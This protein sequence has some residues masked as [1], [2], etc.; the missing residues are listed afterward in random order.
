MIQNMVLDKYKSERLKLLGF[1]EPCLVFYTHTD[2]FYHA[3][4]TDTI[5]NS[6]HDHITAAPTILQA[7]EWL[8]EKKNVIGYTMPSGRHWTWFLSVGKWDAASVDE[9]ISPADAYH[10][11][12]STAL[13]FLE[14]PAVSS[15]E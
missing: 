2:K 12:I 3:L 14:R 13:D 6:E 15:P 7:M 10:E 1:N 11:M 9:C 4:K 5:R 8:M